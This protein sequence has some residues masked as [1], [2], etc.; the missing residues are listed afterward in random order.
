MQRKKKMIYFEYCREGDPVSDFEAEKWVE[1]MIS[2]YSDND[3]EKNYIVK[4]SSEC[5]TQAIRILVRRKKI[6]RKNIAIVAGGQSSFIEEDG[7]LTD[8]PV[9]LSYPTEERLYELTGWFDKNAQL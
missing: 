4:Y 8:Y 9:A 6:N 3:P 1:S 2:F 7:A 5:V